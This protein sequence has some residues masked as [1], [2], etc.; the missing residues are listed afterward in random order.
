MCNKRSLGDA[1]SSESYIPS[2]W[3]KTVRGKESR[4]IESADSPLEFTSVHGVDEMGLNMD[5]KETLEMREIHRIADSPSSVSSIED[6][7]VGMI[8]RSMKILGGEE[9]EEASVVMDDNKPAEEDIVVAVR[10]DIS[11]SGMSEKQTPN[12][13]LL[14]QR[15]VLMSL[16]VKFGDH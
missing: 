15:H 4:R 9:G 11:R 8:D 13:G 6:A 1:L 3:R 7:A 2:S 5:V 14:K 12:S 10:Y 16:L